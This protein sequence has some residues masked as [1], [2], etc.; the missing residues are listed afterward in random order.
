MKRA[1][2]TAGIMILMLA[3]N[4]S[5]AQTKK[6]TTTKKTTTVTK[7]TTVSKKPSAAD[8]EAGKA[9]LAKSDCLAC[10]KVDTKVVGPAYN[11]VAKKYPASEANY[12]MLAKKIIAGG[13]GNWGT[14]AMSP[15]PTLTPADAKKMAQYILSLN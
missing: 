8:I 4:Y 10:H 1:V 15:H 6:V 9:L 5:F 14:M 3:T 2:F 13:S 11:D 12:D 7:T